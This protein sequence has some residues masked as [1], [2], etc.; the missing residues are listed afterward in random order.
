MNY[1]RGFMNLKE[2][3]QLQYEP[4]CQKDNRQGDTKIY[5]VV[6]AGDPTQ[7]RFCVFVFVFPLCLQMQTNS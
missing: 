1:M 4:T 7:L 3:K 5:V 2:Q 6:I